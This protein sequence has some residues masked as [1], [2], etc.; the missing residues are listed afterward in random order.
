MKAVSYS[1]LIFYSKKPKFFVGRKPE[2]CFFMSLR[3]PNSFYLKTGAI[4]KN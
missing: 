1:Y 3:R 2:L 4:N